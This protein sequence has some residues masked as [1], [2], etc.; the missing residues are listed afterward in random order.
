MAL[1]YA[2]DEDNVHVVGHHSP[3]ETVN[4]GHGVALA[5]GRRG[6]STPRL[7]PAL[8]P[9]GGRTPEDDSAGELPM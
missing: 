6:E 2:V 7:V 3:G 8:R 9:G 5:L 4:A 1:H